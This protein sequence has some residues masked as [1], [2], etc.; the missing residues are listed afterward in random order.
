MG[1][2]WVV[3]TPAAEQPA[4]HSTHTREEE[5]ER[6]GVCPHQILFWVVGYSLSP[7]HKGGQRPKR[8]DYIIIII[9]TLSWRERISL[10][11]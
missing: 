9:L 8:V 3:G 11:H 2:G 10:I 6:V 4:H 5:E 1:V 7:T